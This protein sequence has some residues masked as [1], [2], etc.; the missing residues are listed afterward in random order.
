MEFGSLEYLMSLQIMTSWYYQQWQFCTPFSHAQQDLFNVWS[1]SDFLQYVCDYLTHSGH[2]LLS[3][4]LDAYST[5]LSPVL[6]GLPIRG[7]WLEEY[8]HASVNSVSFPA[9]LADP[10]ETQLPPIISLSFAFSVFQSPSLQLILHWFHFRSA[11][12]WHKGR[13]I[14]PI[15][16]MSSNCT[17]H[18]LLGG[19][20]PADC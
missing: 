17:L 4:L 19:R 15:S 11:S 9:V 10:H 14:N 8:Q 1:T 6:S 18:S 2:S 7:Q 20:F 5:Q 12:W 13:Q 3:A 16:I